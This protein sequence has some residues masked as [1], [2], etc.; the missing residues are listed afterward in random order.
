M[1]CEVQVN[2]GVVPAS[3]EKSVGVCLSVLVRDKTMKVEME[4]VLMI[5]LPAMWGKG[6]IYTRERPSS[7]EVVRRRLPLYMTY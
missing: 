2:F 7:F 1:M 5:G 4:N 3:G 6:P